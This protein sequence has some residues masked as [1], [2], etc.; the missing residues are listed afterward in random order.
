MNQFQNNLQTKP[1]HLTHSPLA[2]ILTF[3]FFP[4]MFIFPTL[5]HLL[6]S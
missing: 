4:S 3:P 6:P 2:F 1:N 5:I